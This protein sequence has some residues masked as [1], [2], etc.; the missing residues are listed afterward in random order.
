MNRKQVVSILVSLV[1]VFSLAGL[2]LAQA[3]KGGKAAPAPEQ[4]APAPAPTPAGENSDAQDLN[5][6]TLEKLM[7]LTGIDMIVAKK[8]VAAR[9]FKKKDEI[10]TK[11][12]MTQEDFNKIARSVTV[13]PPA[14]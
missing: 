6:A 1:L 4:K 7:T 5:S 13:R 3:K 11:K 12:I 8:I 2:S 9:P 10:V 14:K